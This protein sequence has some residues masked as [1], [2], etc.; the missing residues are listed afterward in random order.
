MTPKLK[1]GIE[2]VRDYDRSLPRIAAHPSELNQVWTN[3]IDNAVDAMEGRGRL[4]GRHRRPRR[5]RRGPHR[6]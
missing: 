2:V 3:L 1:A 4:R 6:R 5:P